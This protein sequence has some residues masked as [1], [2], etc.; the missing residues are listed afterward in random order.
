MAAT[1]SGATPMQAGFTAMRLGSII[2]FIPFFFV[3][4]PALILNGAPIQILVV[5]VSALAGVLLIASSTQG[6]L[7]GYGSF[8][9]GAMAMVVRTIV[10]FGGLLF[11]F[12]G[13][14]DLGIGHWDA[15]MAGAVLAAVGLGIGLLFRKRVAA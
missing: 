6:Y 9:D 12:P 2:Y 10:F 3:L 14:E 7:V 13:S 11:A 4:E 15:V 1:I 5:L 8:G